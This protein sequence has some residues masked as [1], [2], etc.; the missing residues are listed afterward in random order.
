MNSGLPTHYG[1]QIN[2]RDVIIC[3]NTNDNDNDNNDAAAVAVAAAAA[4]A[5][6]DDDLD[7]D[8]D[9]CGLAI[10]FAEFRTYVD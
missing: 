8:D 3:E 5:D 2:I 4:A 6:D 7:D 1:V 10:H 9:A